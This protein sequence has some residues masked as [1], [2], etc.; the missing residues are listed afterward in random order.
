M[1]N[2]LISKISSFS[3]SITPTQP[4]LIKPNK[5]SHE[6]LTQLLRRSQ[7]TCKTKARC[8]SQ[9]WSFTLADSEENCEVKTNE[10]T[11]SFVSLKEILYLIANR[12]IFIQTSPQTMTQ[13]LSEKEIFP[14]LSRGNFFFDNASGKFLEIFFEFE[15]YFLAKFRVDKR[16][17]F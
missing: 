12:C 16:M 13:S 6:T 10:R 3:V 7:T 17:N 5:Q 2:D 8:C 11:W 4:T 14:F 1:V 9:P 15:T